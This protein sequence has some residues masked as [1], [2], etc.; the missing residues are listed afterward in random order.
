MKLSEFNYYLPENLIAQEPISIR[1]QSRLMILNRKDKSIN[2]AIFED[3]ANYLEKGDV[4]VLNDTRVLKARL[5]ARRKSGGKLE[6][7]LLK[8]KEPGLWEVLVKPGRKAPLGENIIFAEGKCSAEV[9][10][11]TPFGG[12]LIKFNTANTKELMNQYGRMPTPHYIKKDLERPD[13]YQTVYAKKEGAVAAPT[14]GLHFTED[15]INR[16]I[17][18]GVEIVY[19]TLHCGLATF[20]PVKNQDIG[21]HRMETEAFEIDSQAQDAIN[22]AILEKRR[23]VAVGTTV[24]RAL[25]SA[26]VKNKKGVFQIEK[27]RGETSLYIYPGYKFG[28]INALVTNFHLPCSTNLIL[29]AA[30]GG[31]DFVRKAYQNAIE[32][33]FRFYSFGDAMLVI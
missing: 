7:L 32:K 15:L 29:L 10:G 22:Q 18:K 24:V 13:C 5:I 28:I 20:R 8:E 9:L 21:K 31:I 3:I 27:T 11:K 6:I 19:I 2:E 33:I 1:D 26:K 4:L 25:E 12:R 16:L 23:I 17:A 30:F 14:A